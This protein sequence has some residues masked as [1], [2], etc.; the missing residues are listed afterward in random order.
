MKK[1]E[2]LEDMYALVND[3]YTLQDEGVLTEDLKAK[4][5]WKEVAEAEGVEVDDVA[6]T[7]KTLEAACRRFLA[8]R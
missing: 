8:A 4:K 5:G 3:L 1:C 6:D 2:A 7:V